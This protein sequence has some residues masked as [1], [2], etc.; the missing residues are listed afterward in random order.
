MR[1]FKDILGGTLEPEAPVEPVMHRTATDMRQVVEQAWAKQGGYLKGWF[2]PHYEQLPQARQETEIDRE[3][4]ECSILERYAGSV[5]HPLHDG[6]AK[7]KAKLN[8]TAAEAMQAAQSLTD[9][10]SAVP[11]THLRLH[12]YSAT[13]RQPVLEQAWSITDAG[14]CIQMEWRPVPMVGGDE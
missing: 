5:P 7:R 14:G 1:K 11:T 12:R 9:P 10:T 2:D 13:Q 4:V 6:L 8:G 3:R